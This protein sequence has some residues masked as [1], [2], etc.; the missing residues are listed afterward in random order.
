MTEGPPK[1]LSRKANTLHPALAYRSVA[2][3]LA[4]LLNSVERVKPTYTKAR[5]KVIVITSTAAPIMLAF[6]RFIRRAEKT[7]AS[8]LKMK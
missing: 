1:T 2:T 6:S 8:P 3:R 7:P 4:E 5:L